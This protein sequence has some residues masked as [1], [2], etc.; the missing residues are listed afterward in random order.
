MRLCCSDCD[1][2]PVLERAMGVA[3]E[4]DK[5]T[6]R[7]RRYEV[8]IGCLFWYMDGLHA[9]PAWRELGRRREPVYEFEQ[10]PLCTANF[11]ARFALAFVARDP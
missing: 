2:R 9:A 7:A 10:T 11:N 5:Q 6:R 3:V 8:R 1:V 4:G